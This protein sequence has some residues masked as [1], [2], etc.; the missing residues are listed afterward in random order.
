MFSAARL[1]MDG[2]VTRNRV[3]ENNGLLAQLNCFHPQN[4]S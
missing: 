2:K 4:N 3:K 1:W